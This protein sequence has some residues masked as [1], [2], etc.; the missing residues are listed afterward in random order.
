MLRPKPSDFVSPRRGQKIRLHV[1]GFGTQCVLWVTHS[2]RETKGGGWSIL[3]SATR[4]PGARWA[5]VGTGRCSRRVSRP[6]GRASA[7]LLHHPM[8][9]HFIYPGGF[10][11]DISSSP[12]SPADRTAMELVIYHCRLPFLNVFVVNVFFLDIN[13]TGSPF[14]GPPPNPPSGH[15]GRPT[16][17]KRS[18]GRGRWWRSRSCCGTT[19]R[20]ASPSPPPR[21]P[22]GGGRGP[23]S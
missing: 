22:L 17:P 15:C 9:P 16:E 13:E 10:F 1:S 12:Y 14:L 2:H 4:A 23:S 20:R 6:Q 18:P 3:A 7:W 8:H 21:P 19:R 5:R 11:C